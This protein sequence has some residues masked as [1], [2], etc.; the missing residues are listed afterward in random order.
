MFLLERRR[1]VSVLRSESNLQQ[2]GRQRPRSSECLGSFSGCSN[3]GYMNATAAFTQET[4]V[5]IRKDCGN[6]GD[7]RER[8][9]FWCF[10][11]DVESGR[12]V[13][14]SETR[15][16]IERSIFAEPREQFGVTLSWPEQADVA[17]V[18]R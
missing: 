8:N 14:I 13:Q 16:E 10:T 11:A 5:P 12:S 17:K 9:F 7:N 4:A 2:R 15:F 1:A 6:L 3:C 18:Q